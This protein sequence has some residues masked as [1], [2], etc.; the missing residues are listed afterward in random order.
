MIFDISL[1]PVYVED[2]LKNE[3]T[4]L[5]TRININNIEHKLNHILDKYHKLCS[6]Y[7]NITD[8]LYSVEIN[9]EMQNMIE[10]M[11]ENGMFEIKIYK[12]IDD[13]AIITLS[14]SVSEYQHWSQLY[15]TLIR[16]LTDNSS[17][18]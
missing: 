15:E 5:H 6:Y 11:A 16:K 14:K 13:K 7:L 9:C 17:K 4:T 18:E 2:S 8:L 12:S 10:N 3:Y 1:F